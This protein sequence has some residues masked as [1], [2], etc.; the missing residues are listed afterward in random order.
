MDKRSTGLVSRAIQYRKNIPYGE[1]E[2]MVL[3][4]RRNVGMANEIAAYV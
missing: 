3:G 2:L 1:D 4:Q